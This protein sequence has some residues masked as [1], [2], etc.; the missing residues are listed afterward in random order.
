MAV[1]AVGSVTVAQ[2]EV[3][4]WALE[5]HEGEVFGGHDGI[6]GGDDVVGADDVGEDLCDEGGL[7]GIVDGG[8]AAYSLSFPKYYRHFHHAT[9]YTKFSNGAT[10]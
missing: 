6:D 8:R 9:M 7:F 10:F 1:G 4:A 2:E 5:Q 3:A